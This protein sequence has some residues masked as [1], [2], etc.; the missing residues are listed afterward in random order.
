M[1]RHILPVCLSLCLAAIS[2]SAQQMESAS[3]VEIGTLFGLSRISTGG[4]GA[5]LIGL[6]SA[7]GSS[8]LGN[9]SI[10]VSWFPDERFSIGPEFSLG[11]FSG[12][13]VSFTSAY[14]AG[15]I[16]FHSGGATMSG[17]YVFGRGA[18]RYI[19]AEA[20]G[21]S[22]SDTD[23]SLGPGWAIAGVR[24]AVLS[25]GPKAGIDDGLMIPESTTSRCCLVLV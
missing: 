19:S 11:R 3:G 21:E 7:L 2:V 24:E 25:R 15:R 4:E 14:L 8:V 13:G 17:A 1:S 23:V 20:S 16:A 5:T 18:L 9:P 12:E 22:E 10:Y 6:P